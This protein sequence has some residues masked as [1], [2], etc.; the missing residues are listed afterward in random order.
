MKR[1]KMLRRIKAFFNS[2]FFKGMGSVLNLSG[3]Y[4]SEEHQ[5]ILNRTD[6]EALASDWEAVG[7]D[8][9]KALYGR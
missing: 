1:L 8:F 2:P 3:N 4:Y 7:R 5:R 9:R 6:A